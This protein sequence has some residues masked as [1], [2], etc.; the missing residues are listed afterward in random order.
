MATCLEAQHLCGSEVFDSPTP[1]SVRYFMQQ[2]NA[3]SYLAW[4]NMSSR[5]SLFNSSLDPGTTSWLCCLACVWTEYISC[6]ECRDTLAGSKRGRC[7]S[8]ADVFGNKPRKACV[9]Q[10]SPSLSACSTGDFDSRRSVPSQNKLIPSGSGSQSR[11]TG[12]AGQTA[13][14]VG[15]ERSLSGMFPL[16]LLRFCYSCNKF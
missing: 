10:G 9:W 5:C 8:E 13:P 15:M 2:E 6:A 14:A 16:L 12:M 7:A 4:I 11:H 3:I 1:I